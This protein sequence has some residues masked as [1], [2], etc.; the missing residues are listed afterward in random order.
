ME[1]ELDY[2]E[3]RVA[4]LIARVHE[5]DAQNSRLAAALGESLRD[6]AELKFALEETRHRVAAL[7]DRLPKEEE[8]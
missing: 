1:H 3:S 4:A 6:N 7:I 8:A 5:L 2:L